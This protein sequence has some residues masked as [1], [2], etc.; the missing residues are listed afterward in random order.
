MT[1]TVQDTEVAQ[2]A[3]KGWF[4]ADTATFGDRLAGARESIGLS[5]KEVANRLGV[6]QKTL[7]AWENDLSEPRS[8]KLQ[9]LAGLL[10]VSLMWLL[11]GEGEGIESPD[12][13][14]PDADASAMLSEMRA[15]RTEIGK[16]SERLGRLEKRLRLVLAERAP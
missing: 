4:S 7:V 12:E 8:N 6:R 10:G 15:L 5:Q 11:T 1:E 13:R 2:E 16:A 9:M 3:G 14:R